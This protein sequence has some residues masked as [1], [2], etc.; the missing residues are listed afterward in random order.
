MKRSHTEHTIIPI[1]LFQTCMLCINSL[2]WAGEYD[3]VSSYANAEH[4]KILL[5]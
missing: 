1:R 5:N 2:T 3:M 4:M